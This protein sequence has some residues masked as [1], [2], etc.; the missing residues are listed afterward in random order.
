MRTNDGQNAP[1]ISTVFSQFYN[2][3]QNQVYQT[4]ITGM[5]FAV[6]GSN[7]R[8]LAVYTGQAS[9]GLGTGVNEDTRNRTWSFV[10]RSP[11]GR[12]SR[13]FVFG[14]KAIQEGDLRVDTGESTIVQSVVTF[15]N[16][17]VGTFN[18]I[19]GAHP[20]WKGYA[21][22]GYNDHWARVYRKAGG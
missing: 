13:L 2:H 1:A 4:T 12:K 14:A 7:V 9:W 5:E 15:L 20:T 17:A 16:G 18:S 11:D 21:N 19:S 3:I 22:V 6:R 8:N 10:G